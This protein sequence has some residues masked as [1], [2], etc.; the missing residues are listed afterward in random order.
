DL[1]EEVLLRAVLLARDEGLVGGGDL[2]LHL[3]ELVAAEG[4]EGLAQLGGDPGEVGAV[5]RRRRGGGRRRRLGLGGR[6]LGRVV[7]ALSGILARLALVARGRLGGRR[8][9]T[10]GS[11]GQQ[12]RAELH[13][14]GGLDPVERRLIRRAGDR[15]DDLV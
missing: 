4:V 13:L 9:R 6:I 5:G 8:G 12:H 3:R 10:G 7:S 1:A 15:D 2:G 11:A 14:R